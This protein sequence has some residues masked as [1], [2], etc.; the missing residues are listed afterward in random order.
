VV[1]PDHDPLLWRE[2]MLALDRC[3]RR[4]DHPGQA[5]LLR[6]RLHLQRGDIASAEADLR[7]GAVTRLAAGADEAEVMFLRGIAA[8]RR[9]DLERARPLLERAATAAPDNPRAWQALSVSLAFLDR[10]DDALR[11][12]DTVVR[13]APHDGASWFNRGLFH[14][15]HGRRQQAEQDLLSASRLLPD[16]TRTLQLLQSIATGREVVVDT[17]LPMIELVASEQERALARD[18]ETVMDSDDEAMLASLGGSPEER[19]RWLDLLEHRYR[20]DGD[21]DDRRV[22][23][24]ARH[25]GAEHGAVR[26]LLAPAWPDDLSTRERLLLILADRAD[27]LAERSRELATELPGWLEPALVVAA[28]ILL[29]DVGDATDAAPLLAEGR[30]RWPEHRGL[31]ELDGRLP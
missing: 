25:A 19:A 16:N 28:V 7:H 24:E 26:R 14:L 6:A 15:Q 29:H 2:A 27:G 3:V 12:F 30:R 22:L 11:A 5:R 31:A 21:P 23:A 10:H 13:L 20:Q 18:L 1:E 4:E 17:S 9:G 8:S